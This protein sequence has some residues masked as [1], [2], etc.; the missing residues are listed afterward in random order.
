MRTII[1]ITPFDDS[2]PSL[3]LETDDLPESWYQDDPNTSILYNY[4]CEQVPDNNW[5]DMVCDTVEYHKDYMEVFV[6]TYR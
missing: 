3:M 2:L 6:S 4:I 5:E 1:H